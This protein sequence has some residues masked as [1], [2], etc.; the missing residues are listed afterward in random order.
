MNYGFSFA[1]ELGSALQCGVYFSLSAEAPFLDYV[2]LQRLFALQQDAQ[3]Q[4]LP[5]SVLSQRSVTISNVSALL[6]AYNPKDYWY[7]WFVKN[8][9]NP[10]RVIQ[11]GRINN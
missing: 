2:S 3:F 7:H 10:S 5:C 4:L 11:E 1:N 6:V 9:Q 8:V